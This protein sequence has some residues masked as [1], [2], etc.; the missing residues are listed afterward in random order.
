MSAHAQAHAPTMP[1]SHAHAPHIGVR[2]LLI[3]YGALILLMFLT[4]GAALLDLARA[5]FLIAM[6]IASVKMFLIVL[7][8]M[9]VRYSPKLI[10]VV[11]LGSFFW[12]LLLV[13][14]VLNDY[15]TRGFLNV[16]GK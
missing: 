1:S 6:G 3:V 15:F 16:P 13:G 9:H 4:L 5:N 8:F 10:W 12:L 7:Y 11:S 14:G 2:T